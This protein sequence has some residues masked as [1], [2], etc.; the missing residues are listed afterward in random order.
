MRRRLAALAATGLTLALLVPVASASAA[1][2]ISVR[3]GQSIQ[4]A[5]DDA[6]AGGVPPPT[7]GGPLTITAVRDGKL[8]IRNLKGT[9]FLFDPVAGGFVETP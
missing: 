3:P 9:E 5:I 7:K 2:A 4:A 8:V 6:P 1:T